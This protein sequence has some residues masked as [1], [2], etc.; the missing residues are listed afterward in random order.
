MGL[1]IALV[2]SPVL[3]AILLRWA[4]LTE[5]DVPSVSPRLLGDWVF[6]LGLLALVRY[7]ERLPLSSIGLRRPS[8][9]DLLWGVVGFVLGAITFVFTGPLVQALN[10]ETTTPGIAKLATLPVWF[11]LLIVI[12]AGVT[13]EVLFRGYPIERLAAWTGRIGL[14]ALIAYAVFVILHIP[15]WGL[16]GTLQIGV[17]AIV[18][19]VLYVRLRNLWPCILMHVLN[20]AYAFILLPMFLPQ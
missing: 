16:G 11:R 15:F 8:G 7:W 20:D 3:G 5:F 18:V 13:E 1:A 9:R 2:A 14:G 6:A 19:T 12:T 4:G 17:W 10:L